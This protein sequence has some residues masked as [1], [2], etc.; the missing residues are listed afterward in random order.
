[1]NRLTPVTK[2]LLIANV[3]VFL[4]QILINASLGEGT[5]EIWGALWSRGS[6]RLE[7]WQFIT[8]MFMHGNFGHI[9]FNMFALYMF[10]P[11]LEDNWGPKRFFQ[12]YMIC[13]ILAGAAQVLLTVGFS[14]AVGA[15]GA[16]MGVLAAFA[17]LFPE[18]NLYFMF[19]PIPL[20]AKWVIPA[21]I[22]IDLFGGIANVPDDNVA[23][24]AHLGGAVAGLAMAYFWRRSDRQRR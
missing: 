16:I 13:G 8:H 17:Y 12:F 15:S 1:M 23:H 19:I 9:F 18:M 10:G 5:A 22:A 3:V 2:N 14:Y 21:I 20:K 24:F 7:I 4:L 6:G 11:M